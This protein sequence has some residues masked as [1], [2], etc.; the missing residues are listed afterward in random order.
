MS[1]VIWSPNSDLENENLFLLCHCLPAVGRRAP[2]GAC[3]H[4]EVTAFTDLLCY[5]GVT[6]RRRGNLIEKG[7]IASFHSP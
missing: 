7:E 5:L 4:A 6:A 1:I 3:L 2:E